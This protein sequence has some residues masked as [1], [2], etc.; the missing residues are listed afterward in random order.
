MSEQQ[1]D[2]VQ[3][4]NSKGTFNCQAALPWLKRAEYGRIILTLRLPG[5]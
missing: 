2:E 1:W 4:I 5:R 3:A